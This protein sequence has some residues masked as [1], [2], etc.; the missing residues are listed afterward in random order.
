MPPVDSQNCLLVIFV[1]AQP[2]SRQTSAITPNSRVILIVI[3]S[4]GETS[5]FAISPNPKFSLAKAPF[6]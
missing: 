2:A 6:G 5:L 1:P 3:P 4:L